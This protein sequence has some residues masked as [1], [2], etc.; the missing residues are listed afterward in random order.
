MKKNDAKRE[1]AV[2]LR[3]DQ[4]RDDAPVVAAKGSG[5]TAEKMIELAREYSVPLQEDPSLVEVLSKMEIN[6]Q[7]PSELYG[8]VAEVLAFVYKAD[9]K[10]KGGWNG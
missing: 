4:E 9:Q 1:K 7:I 5:M 3:Y 10:S 6:E 8:V 2:A